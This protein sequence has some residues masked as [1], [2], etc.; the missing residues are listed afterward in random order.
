MRRKEL[1]LAR[2]RYGIKPLYYTVQDG[3]FLFG[4]EIKALLS[5]PDIGVSVSIPALNEYFSFQNIFSHLTLFEGIHL[6]PAA[7]PRSCGWRATWVWG[8]DAWLLSTFR[9]QGIS[10]C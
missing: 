1:F 10:R 7:H 8:I 9:Q 6:L 3:V 4:S 5:H 2:D